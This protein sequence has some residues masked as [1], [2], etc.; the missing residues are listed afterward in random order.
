[1][2]KTGR[3]IGTVVAAGLLVGATVLAMQY[4]M[5][6]AADT[7]AKSPL[8]PAAP[9]APAGATPVPIGTQAARAAAPVADAK[10]PTGLSLT[11]AG[12]TSAPAGAPAASGPADAVADDGLALMQSGRLFQAQVRLSEA[13]RGG[14]AGP[15]G[16][17]V[18]DTLVG[19]ADRVQFAG[20][21]LPDDPYS[22]SYAVV[23][24]D[25]V[26]S[27]GQKFLIPLELVMKLN[28]LSSHGIAAGQQLKVIQGPVNIEIFKSRHE[29]Q[30]WLGDVCIRVHPVA[31][32]KSDTTPEGT[33]VVK[34]KMRNPPYQPAHKARSEFRDGGAPDNPLGTRWIDIGNH[35]GV[36]GT[37]DPSS[38]G[39]DVSEGCVRM[40]NK[41][42]EELFDLVVV[43]ASKVTI[44]P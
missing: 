30:A 7:S 29:L 3:I 19:L 18:R 10:A 32:G 12:G 31:I 33:F 38:I 6:P 4:F 39:G 41:E 17:T 36:H 25:S 8:A 5:P 34:N 43:G 22:K 40:N 28:G 13:L 14:V 35:Y 42:V 24:G 15:K 37:I 26:T 1:M 16:K 23:R 21:R 9:A 27:I 2:T 44:R 11:G 20:Q